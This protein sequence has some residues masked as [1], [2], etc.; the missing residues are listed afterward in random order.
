MHKL[1]K[2]AHSLAISLS[3]LAGFVDAVGFLQLGGHFVS[4]MS[5]NSTQLAVGIAAGNIEKALL[6]MAII[7]LFVSGAMLGTA[8]RHFSVRPVF[9]VLSCVTLLLFLAAA[10]NELGLP[11]LAIASMALAMGAE[12][13]SFKREG[14]V[15]GLTYMTGTLVKLGQHLVNAMTGGEKFAW[16][17]YLLLWLGLLTGGVSGALSFYVFDLHALW[18]AV[19]WAGAMVLFAVR[20]QTD[21]KR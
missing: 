20:H 19:A 14:D 2:K 5:G 9:G 3:F 7:V 18:I 10:S 17:P 15:V 13:S 21:S 11:F 6:L 1:H 8:I 4:F 16:L 12:N